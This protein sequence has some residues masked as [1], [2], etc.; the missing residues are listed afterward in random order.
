MNNNTPYPGYTPSYKVVSKIGN[1]A[2]TCFVV[3]LL[4]L[5]E[6]DEIQCAQ[7][8]E[9]IEATIQHTRV[10]TVEKIDVVAPNRFD[11]LLRDGLRLP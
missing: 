2:R 1:Y 6:L 11:R 8:R 5:G 4:S 9:R 7:I 10:A 3:E